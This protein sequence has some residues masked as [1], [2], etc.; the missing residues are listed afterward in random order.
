MA[1]FAQFGNELY[2]GARSYNIVGRRKLWFTIAITGMLLSF[3]VLGTKGINPGIEFRGGSEFTLTNVTSN[4]GDPARAVLAEAGVTEAARITTVGTDSLRIQTEELT[5]DQ[6]ATVRQGLADAYDLDLTGVTST[7]IGPTWGADVTSKA[8]QGLVIFLIL[9]SVVM[10]A[11]FRTW[12]MSASAVLALVH[13]LVIT[14]GLYALVGFEMTPAS[15]IGFLTILGYSLYD[16]V[17]VFDKV[18]ENTARLLD[19]DRVTYE[20]A[21][22]LALNQTLV[23]SINTSIVGILPVASILFVGTLLLGAGT[24]R[25]IALALFIGM[26][27]STISSIFIATPLLVWLRNREDKIGNHTARVLRARAQRMERGEATGDAMAATVLGTTVIPGGHLGQTA[28]P[29]RKKREQ[30]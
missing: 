21:A 8:I 15:V 12:K 4:S 14:V 27:V 26:I 30:R 25:D 2:T 20:E 6:I 13:D 24:L 10:A 22:N 11:Y 16:T 23:R 19:Q 7:F 18:R 17:V 5:A 9:V 29:K 3:L 28:Q 1:S